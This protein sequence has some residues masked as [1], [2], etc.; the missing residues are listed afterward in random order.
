MAL[1]SLYLSS[2]CADIEEY[3]EWIDGK[4]SWSYRTMAK[5]RIVIAFNPESVCAISNFPDIKIEPRLALRFFEK[6]ASPH[7]H[8]G[9]WHI[10]WGGE[11]KELQLL[12]FS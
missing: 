12:S 1:P 6:D 2:H 11:I 9:V 8:S 5:H 10:G 4:R 7:P 3:V